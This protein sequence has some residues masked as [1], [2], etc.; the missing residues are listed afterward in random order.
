LKQQKKKYRE[1]GYGEDMR[2]RQKRFLLSVVQMPSLR[3]GFLREANLAASFTASIRLEGSAQP[4]P[5]MS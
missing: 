1:K 4:F 3:W 2:T 5:A